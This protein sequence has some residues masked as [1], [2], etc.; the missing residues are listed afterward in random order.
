MAAVVGKCLPRET[1]RS[2]AGGDIF[3]VAACGLDKLET[4]WEVSSLRPPPTYYIYCSW[5]LLRM[6]IPPGERVVAIYF[7]GE[8]ELVF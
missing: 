3:G 6:N 2:G 8:E 4:V 5:M 7:C 1:G